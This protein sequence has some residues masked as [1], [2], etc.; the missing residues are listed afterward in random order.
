MLQNTL[1]YQIIENLMPYG[2]KVEKDGEKEAEELNKILKDE[3]MEYLFQFLSVKVFKKQK[4]TLLTNEDAEAIS[5]L[6]QIPKENVT[7]DYA[8]ALYDKLDN[9]NKINSI[10]ESDADED[11]QYIN[12]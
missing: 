5:Q 11:L 10:R 4:V 6:E 1:G 7:V 12:K 9:I 3:K 2:L 8:L